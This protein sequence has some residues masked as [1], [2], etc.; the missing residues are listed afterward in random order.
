MSDSQTLWFLVGSLATDFSK[1][2]A[3]AAAAVGAVAMISGTVISAFAV[4]PLIVAIAVGAIAGLALEMIDQWFAITPQVVSAMD[5]AA[6]R[7]EWSYEQHLQELKNRATELASNL[8]EA[9]AEAI[10]QEVEEYVRSRFLNVIWM[11]S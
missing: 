5:R 4:G 9:A 6:R 11:R 8:V 10:L 2:G 7:D 1:I 3:S